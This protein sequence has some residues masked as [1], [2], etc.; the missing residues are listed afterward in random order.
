MKNSGD[1]YLSC[2]Y[3]I[4]IHFNKIKYRFVVLD[5]ET[6]GLI[7]ERNLHKNYIKDKI[8]STDKYIVYNS[9]L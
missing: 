4:P 1:S 6:N 2:E 5:L 3:Y 8:D 9:Q 7:Y